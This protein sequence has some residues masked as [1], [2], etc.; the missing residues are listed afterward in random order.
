MAGSG[1]LGRVT[2]P[3]EST[4]AAE[5]TVPRQQL[6]PPRGRR[7]GPS[8]T[9]GWVAGPLAAADDKETTMSSRGTQFGRTMDYFRT[10]QLD[11]ASAA[12]R[13][14]AGIVDRRNAD[15]RVPTNKTLRTR[16]ARTQE[17]AQAAAQHE[18][19]EVAR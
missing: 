19:V 7:G 6:P 12:L 4:E 2:S 17:T 14:T 13:A 3:S 11:E 8:L 16:R 10:A 9:P 15:A 1:V 18:T 5:I